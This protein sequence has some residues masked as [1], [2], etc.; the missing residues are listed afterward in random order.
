MLEQWEADRLLHLAKVY[1]AS[2]VVVLAG[3]V[4]ADYPI[5]SV[6]ADDRFLLDVWQSRRNRAKAR[7]QLRYRRTLVLARMCTAVPHSNPDGERLAGAH[8]HS[9]REGYED[10]WARAVG[11]YGRPA[12]ALMDFCKLINLP[13]PDL[14]GGV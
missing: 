10:R 5:E 11:P 12:E 1:A 3:G 4:D 7:F 9:Y 6:D 8:F 14:E 2:T 13:A